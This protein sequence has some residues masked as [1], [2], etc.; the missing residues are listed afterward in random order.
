MPEKTNGLFHSAA[1]RR[2]TAVATSRPPPRQNL[3]ETSKL[4]PVITRAVQEKNID[5]TGA[6]GWASVYGEKKFRPIVNT[7]LR[8]YRGSGYRGRHDVPYR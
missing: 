1:R 8:E 2:H 6:S 7:A 4:A 5:F 3:D